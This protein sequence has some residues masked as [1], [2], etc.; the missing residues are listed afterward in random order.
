VLER[1]RLVIDDNYRRFLFLAAPD[2]EPAF[3]AGLIVLGL[4]DS[5]RAFAGLSPLRNA[6]H[7]DASTLVDSSIDTLPKA[8]N[9][10]ISKYTY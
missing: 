5:C 2:R 7:I 3:V 10:T 9:K 4:G 8:D 1:P 6:K